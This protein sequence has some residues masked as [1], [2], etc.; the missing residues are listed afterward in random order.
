VRNG[1]GGCYARRLS[2][3]AERRKEEGPGEVSC[4]T[5]YRL[6]P[7]AEGAWLAWL[8]RHSAAAA[9]DGQDARMTRVRA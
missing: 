5:F 8:L 9:G 2:Y 4:G 3:N 7:A 1:T 6:A